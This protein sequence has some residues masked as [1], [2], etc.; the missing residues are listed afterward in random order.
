MGFIS[1]SCIKCIFMVVF[2]LIS[3]IRGVFAWL[4]FGCVVSLGE[5]GLYFSIC[6]FG[7]F[8]VSGFGLIGVIW[9]IKL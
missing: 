9:S 7:C 8:G 1:K 4:S 2:S 3:L 6:F 5:W